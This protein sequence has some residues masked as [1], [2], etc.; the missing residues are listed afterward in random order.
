MFDGMAISVGQGEASISIKENTSE[1][2][3]TISLSCGI[4]SWKVSE[5]LTTSFSQTISVTLRSKIQ[6][7]E[8]TPDAAKNLNPEK[9][10]E[11]FSFSSSPFERKKRKIICKCKPKSKIFLC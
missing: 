7:D 6:Q 8:N 1:G 4:P 3:V 2:S 10:L 5:T 11:T 9:L